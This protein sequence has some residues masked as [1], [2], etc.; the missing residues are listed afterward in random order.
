MKI[1]SGIWG[2]PL[3]ASIL[4]NTLARPFDEEHDPQMEEYVSHGELHCLV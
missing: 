3:L 1:V 4:E 2:K